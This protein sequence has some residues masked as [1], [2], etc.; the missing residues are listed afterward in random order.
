VANQRGVHRHSQTSAFQKRP[1]L[2]RR[3]VPAGDLHLVPAVALCGGLALYFSHSGVGRE[4]VRSSIGSFTRS[5]LV[6]AGALTAHL[7][8]ALLA[9]PSLGLVGLIA[10]GLIASDIERHSRDHIRHST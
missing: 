7:P 10:C 2:K 9:L 6:A 4:F 5:R 3:P 1:P 8:P